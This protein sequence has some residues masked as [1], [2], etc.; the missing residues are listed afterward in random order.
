MSGQGPWTSQVVKGTNRLF[1]VHV[2]VGHKPAGL[3]GADRQDGQP[4]FLEFFAGFP[5]IIAVAVTAVADKIDGATWG[6]EDKGR[7]KGTVAVKG[8]AR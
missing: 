1:R 7:P 2:I 8:A 6:S 4:E 5:E 3:I